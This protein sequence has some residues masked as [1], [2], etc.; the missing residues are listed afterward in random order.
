M[1][2][3]M[4]KFKEIFNR[5]NNIDSKIAGIN[6]RLNE[7]NDDRVESLLSDSEIEMINSN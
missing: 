2:K 3:L 4:S 5:L 6:E 1:L 7:I